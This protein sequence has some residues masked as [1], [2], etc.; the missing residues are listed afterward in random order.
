MKCGNP[1]VKCHSSH[2]II[3]AVNEHGVIGGLESDVR[4]FRAMM[5]YSYYACAVVLIIRE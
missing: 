1:M 3:S 2:S 5:S 4:Y